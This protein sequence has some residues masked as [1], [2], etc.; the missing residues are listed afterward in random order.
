[1]KF[2]FAAGGT[3]VDLS[4]YTHDRSG[5][6]TLFRE[7]TGLNDGIEFGD[8]ICVGLW[9]PNVRMV[10]SFRDARVFLAGGKRY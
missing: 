8:L 10:N 2:N 9:K 4:K 7:I 6:I 5:L 1:M 3:A